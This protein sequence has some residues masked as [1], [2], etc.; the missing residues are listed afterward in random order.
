M[1]LCFRIS[2]VF[3]FALGLAVTTNSQMKKPTCDDSDYRPIRI[4]HVLKNA[5]VEVPKPEYP[6]AAAVVNA[7]GQVTVR[8]LID[9]RGKVVSGCALDG[10]PFL[11]KAAVNSM[12]AAKFKPN[13]GLASRVQRTGWR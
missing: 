3:D 4:S 1:H 7:P 10:H 13:F 2:F 5:V 9:L 11:R 6:K 8:V 12:K